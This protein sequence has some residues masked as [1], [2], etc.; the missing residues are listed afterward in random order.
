MGEVLIIDDDEASIFLTKRILKGL[1]LAEQVHY[2][3]N[4]KKGLE[5]IGKEADQL[6]PDLILLDINMPVMDGFGFLQELGKLGFYD[7]S[8]T[9]IVMLSSTEDPREI[10]RAKSHGVTAFIPKPLT[11]EKLLAVLG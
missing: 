3:G 11:R 8:G 6:I 4:G 1:G 10:E 2:A 9:R 7:M 5:L